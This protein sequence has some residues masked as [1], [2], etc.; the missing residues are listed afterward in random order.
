MS[1]TVSE[2]VTAAIDRANE[3]PA[4]CGGSAYID[5]EN[6]FGSFLGIKSSLKHG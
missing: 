3:W 5:R 6:P 2:A 4:W 1:G